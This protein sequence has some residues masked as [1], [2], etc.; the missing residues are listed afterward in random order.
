LVTLFVQISSIRLLS[1]SIHEK[2]LCGMNP[3]PHATIITC[4]KLIVPI[5]VVESLK[6]IVPQL[7]ID[8][9]HCQ[10]SFLFN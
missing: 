8:P 7:E 2:A 3:T 1:F 6:I 10:I 4:Q 9:T 5:R